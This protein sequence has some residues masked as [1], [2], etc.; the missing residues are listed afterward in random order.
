MAYV[1]NID[2]ALMDYLWL[3]RLI[4][5]ILRLVADLPEEDLR[6]IAKLRSIAESEVT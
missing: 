2:M 4:I 6:S 3:I 5:E 1:G